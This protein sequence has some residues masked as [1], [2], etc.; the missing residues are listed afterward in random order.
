[1]TLPNSAARNDDLLSHDKVRLKHISHP[2]EMPPELHKA[3]F[4]VELNRIPILFPHSQPNVILVELHCQL[5][6]VVD[7][8]R[9]E[10]SSLVLL[11]N[12][13]S[14]YFE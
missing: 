8:Y 10:P 11:A 9:A 3:H 4:L 2:E 6:S 5:Q 1:M 12:I 13:D 7:Q 14:F